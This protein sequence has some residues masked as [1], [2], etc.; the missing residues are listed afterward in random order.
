MEILSQPIPLWWAVVAI[1]VY[2]LFGAAVGA[3]EAPDDTSSKSYRFWFRFLNRFAA[4]LH[5]AA[6]KLKVPGEES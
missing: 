6:V 1:L 2:W 5:R 3:M 4:N